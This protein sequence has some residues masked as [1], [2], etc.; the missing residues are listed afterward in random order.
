MRRQEEKEKKHQH[1]MNTMLMKIKRQ[2]VNEKISETVSTVI[3]I[4][5]ATEQANDPQTHENYQ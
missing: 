4:V 3:S 2:I 5:R 1:K